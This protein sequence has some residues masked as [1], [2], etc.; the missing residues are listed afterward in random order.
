MTENNENRHENVNP[1][2]EITCTDMQKSTSE[3][4]LKHPLMQVGPPGFEPESTAPEA[5]SIPG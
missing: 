2:N 5:A 1:E 3:K 4:S